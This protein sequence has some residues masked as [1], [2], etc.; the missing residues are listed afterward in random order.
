MLA[1]VDD[2]VPLAGDKGFD[3]AVPREALDG[4][5]VGDASRLALGGAG[6][7]DDLGVDVQERA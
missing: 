2:E 5:D 4:G 3:F 6:H 7:A 1:F